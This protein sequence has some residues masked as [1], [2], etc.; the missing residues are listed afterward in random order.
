MPWYAI[1][2]IESKLKPERLKFFST[3]A[4]DDIFKL[5]FELEH[6]REKIQGIIL[7]VQIMQK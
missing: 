5:D 1:R 2:T 4:K 3:F 6:I 7:G